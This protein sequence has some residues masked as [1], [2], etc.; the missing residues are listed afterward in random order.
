MKLCIPTT[1]RNGLNSR[2]SEHFGRAPFHIVIDLDTHEIADLS[3]PNDCSDEG[4]GHC[5]P[6]DLLMSHDVKIVVCKG[7]GRGA[8]NRL[9]SNKID[10]LST[11][12]DT[13]QGVLDEYKGKELNLITSDHICEGHHH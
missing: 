9:A 11:S 8:V 2:V 10:V 7:I 12:S 5:M 1:D 4:H 3:K 13:V 6:V